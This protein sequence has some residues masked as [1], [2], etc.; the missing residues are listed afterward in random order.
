MAGGGAIG[1]DN[2]RSLGG[3]VQERRD[4]NI[5]G[6]VHQ[7]GEEGKEIEESKEESNPGRQPGGA[8]CADG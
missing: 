7:P 1:A 3:P 8:G 5:R 6:R 4:R 2:I